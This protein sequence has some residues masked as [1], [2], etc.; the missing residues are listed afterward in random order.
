MFNS[1]AHPRLVKIAIANIT[2]ASVREKL[3]TINHLSNNHDFAVWYIT[4]FCK[5]VKCQKVK[6]VNGSKG[7]NSHLYFYIC[8]V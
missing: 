5:K 1:K 2:E 8:Y 3:K 4:L 7:Q 6:K